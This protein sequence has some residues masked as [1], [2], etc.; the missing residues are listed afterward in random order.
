MPSSSRHWIAYVFRAGVIIVILM[1][2]GGVAN[3]LVGSAPQPKTAD[4]TRAMQTVNVFAVQ[5]VDIR[6][7]WSGFGTAQPIH[8]A[9]IPA[10]ITSTI[11]TL[12]TAIRAGKFVHQGDVIA[13]LDDADFQ[14]QFEVADERLKEVAS[15]KAQ[16]TIE[17]TR[18]KERLSLEEEDL[19]IAR[20]EL[21]NV[22]MR[23]DRGAANERELDQPKR[24]VIAAQRSIVVTNESL[25]R[26][27]QRLSLLEA[28]ARGLDAAK[29][30][31]KLNVDRAII[32]SPID[33]IIEMIDIE[34]G[35]NVTIGQRIARIVDLSSMEVPLQLPAAARQDVIVGSSVTITKPQNDPVIWIGKIARILP[36]DDE[37]ARSTVVLLEI[38]QE[39]ANESFGQLGGRNL[40]TPGTFVM[41][42]AESATSESRWIVPR[43]SIIN[44]RL[45]VVDGD[46]VHSIPV[47]RSFLHEGKFPQLKLLDDQ[48]AVLAEDTTL[49]AGN[50]VIINASVSVRDGQQVKPVEPK[51]PAPDQDNPDSQDNQGNRGDAVKPDAAKQSSAA[52]TLEQANRTTD[53]EATR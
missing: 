9:D 32:T 42:T 43:R 25:D 46:K 49:T 8:S 26:I 12:D 36:T 35:E 19:T 18:L 3:F 45:W 37:Q 15:Q 14:R 23:V 17:T 41:G 4:P 40:L 30:L 51:T 16:L 53:V 39:Y 10:R 6:R 44:E 11:K 2:G 22:Q 52:K 31:A 47:K 21:A 34:L 24:A 7:Q 5:K 13:T 29:K 33:G 28:T 1:I 27:P 20:R 38:K 50:L 48:W